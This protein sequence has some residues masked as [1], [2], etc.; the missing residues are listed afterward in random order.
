[1]TEEEVRCIAREEAMKLLSGE[2]V[3]V[4]GVGVSIQSLVT[5]KRWKGAVKTNSNMTHEQ[6]VA[7]GKK[8]G[9][10]NRKD[11]K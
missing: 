11:I 10:G 7:N 1:M 9:R 2:K 8:D 5:S 3:Q 6:H 4:E